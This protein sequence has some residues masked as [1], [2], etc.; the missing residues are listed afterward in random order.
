MNT[1]A[2][3]LHRFA[4]LLTTL[5][6]F[7]GSLFAQETME[8]AEAYLRNMRDQY[9]LSLTDISDIKAS[10]ETFSEHNGVTHL[11][12]NQRLGGIEI[13]TANLNLSINREG[14]VVNFHQ[15]FVKNIGNKA[16]TF[17]PGISQHDAVIAAVNHYQL[18]P[19]GPLV[20]LEAPSG[21]DQKGIFDKGV[22]SQEPIPVQLK[23]MPM[24]N[25]DLNLVWD[26]SIL[27][28]SA[29]HWWSVRID[30]ITGAVLDEYDWMV[31]CDFSHPESFSVHEQH[32]LPKQPMALL[33]PPQINAPNSYRVYDTPLESPNHGGRTY[34]SN[35]SNALASPFGWHDTNGA[36][37]AEFTN[38]QGNNV[39]AQEDQNGNNGNGARPTG[40]ATLDFDFPVNLTQQPNTYVDAATTNLF[41]WNN[42]IHDVWYQYGFDEASGNFQENN[43]G[44]GATGS[45]F[46][47]ADCQD[48]SGTNNANFG[49]PNDGNNPRMQ[50]FLWNGNSSVIFTV[51][52]PVGIAGS[53]FAVEAGFGPGLTTTPLTANLILANDGSANPTEACNALNNGAAINNNIALVDRA[54]CNFTAKVLNA[55]A[56]GAVACIVC[57]NVGGGPF[58]MGGAAGG[59]TI[60][61][62]MISMADCAILKAQLASGVNVSLSNTGPA[63]DKDGDFDNGII[64]HEY[65][66]GI[67]NRLTGGRNSSNCLGN[68]EQMGEGWSD[69]IGLVMTMENGDQGTDVRGIGTFAIGEPTSGGGIRPAPYSTDMT[70]N[71]FTYIDIQNTGAI[72][73]PHGIGFLWCSM[74]W[75]MTWALI[76]RYGFDPDITNGTGG[77][78]IA[79]QLVTDGMKLQPCS[80]GFVDGRDAILLAD[81]LNNGGAN[82]CLIW[83]AFAKRGLGLSADQGSS[84]SRTD[85]S[86]AY[87][88]PVCAL[89]VDWLDFTATAGKQDIA[90]EWILAREESNQ[91]FEIERRAMNE[92]GFTQVGYVAGKGNTESITRYT[93]PDQEVEAGITYFY[94]LRQLDH[95]GNAAY[96]NTV[97]A[98][99]APE[100]SVTLFPNPTAGLITV[101]IGGGYA[102]I[103]E[104]RVFDVL[105]KSLNVPQSALNQNAIQLDLSAFGRGTYLVKIRLG[106]ELLL[107]KVQVN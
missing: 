35:P 101:E 10:S 34:V 84:T 41:Y 1:R 74:L 39:L 44:R 37:G 67:S 24:P 42:L 88:V 46:V 69:Y 77:N 6:L 17:Q 3:T 106:N 31:T 9:G 100:Y 60:P 55:Q 4:F 58:A 94:R 70:V 72:S 102:A 71:P 92:T 11:Y 26:L 79:M 16:N 90:L 20:W 73:R 54:N 85:G 21:T 7:S 64:A 61:S 18:G 97:T 48:G 53:Y 47:F 87:D 93:Y 12:V 75:E 89:P 29:D 63:V 51:N 38:T 104:I 45:D 105:G 50:M 8:I 66:H 14:R 95:N 103:P 30:A 15:S 32:L 43:Y 33:A 27:P 86:E 65:G 81:T 82:A 23:F 40:G 5:F 107:R 19:T 57:N 98:R 56:A 76:D 83:A 13:Y 62:V 96:S 68:Q 99:I 52:S 80:P 78:N 36:A 25:G 91:G 59:I 2:I 22:L 49:T 28:H